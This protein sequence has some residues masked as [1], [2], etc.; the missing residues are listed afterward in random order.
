MIP[1]AHTNNLHTVFGYAQL[2]AVSCRS[3]GHRSLLGS[4]ELGS[5]NGNM[6][7]LSQLKLRCSKCDKRD[8]E[9]LIPYSECDAR[10]WVA[11]DATPDD[12]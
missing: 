9:L 11:R 10:R 7:A 2:L 8:F 3:C 1:V 6:M 12:A 5:L 4:E